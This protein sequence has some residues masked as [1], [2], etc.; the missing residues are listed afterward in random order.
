[1]LRFDCLSYY[2]AICYCPLVAKSASFEN[3]N[4]GAESR[5]AGYN[6]FVSIFFT[7]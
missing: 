5:F 7:S 1:M 2:Y 4:N 3:Q 6:C